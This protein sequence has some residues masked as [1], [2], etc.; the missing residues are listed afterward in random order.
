M[1]QGL[2]QMF[3]DTLTKVGTMNS[4]QDKVEVIEPKYDYSKEMPK[5]SS[6]YFVVNHLVGRATPIFLRTN[7]T[8]Q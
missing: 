1:K 4:C 6:A 2:E 5:L 8:V 3:E 7:Q